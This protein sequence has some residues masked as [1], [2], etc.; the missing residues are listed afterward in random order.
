MYFHNDKKF[1]LFL[2]KQI[3]RSLVICPKKNLNSED[4]GLVRTVLLLRNFVSH[5]KMAFA[6]EK[7]SA[8]EVCD[9]GVVTSIPESPLSNTSDTNDEDSKS[10]KGAEFDELKK[11]KE[12]KTHWKNTH[13]FVQYN[14]WTKPHPLKRRDIWDNNHVRLP[15]S[16]HSEF[17]KNGRIL[18]RWSLV[19][20]ALGKPI[21]ESQA[22][23]QGTMLMK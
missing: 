20:Q 22:L 14:D 12:L 19:Q 4:P 13:V 9:N 15:C 10:W 8:M 21:L 2:K 7:S 5:F 6:L 16:N 3:F 17:P 18:K 11:H 1:V 23:I